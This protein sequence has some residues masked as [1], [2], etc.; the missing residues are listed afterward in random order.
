MLAYLHLWAKGPLAHF[1]DQVG[2]GLG[3]YALLLA[4]IAILAIGGV[5]VF[6]V[7]LGELWQTIASAWTPSGF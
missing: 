6:G 3:E 1:R 4:F 5:T 2:A 7:R